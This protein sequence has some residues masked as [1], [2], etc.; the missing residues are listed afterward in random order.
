MAK[1][2]VELNGNCRMDFPDDCELCAFIGFEID[3]W[4]TGYCVCR[5]L[6][7]NDIIYEEDYGKMIKDNRIGDK[8][9]NCPIIQVRVEES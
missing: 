6:Q 7:D 4:R 3:E 2:I 5:L 8:L 9:P 1:T